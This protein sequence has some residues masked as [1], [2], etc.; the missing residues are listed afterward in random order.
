MPNRSLKGEVKSPSLVVAPRGG[1]LEDRDP[2]MSLE[3][4][5][6]EQKRQLRR[7]GALD[8]KGAPKRVQGRMKSS[9]KPGLG[10]EPR[11][12]VLGEPIFEVR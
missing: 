12:E 7:M 2:Q 11:K 1:G 4:L 8:E 3:D 6:R 10:I 9:E 5:N